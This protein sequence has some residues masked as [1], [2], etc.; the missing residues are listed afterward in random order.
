LKPVFPR[1]VAERFF[2]SELDKLVDKGEEKTAASMATALGKLI[3][4]INAHPGSG[5]PRYANLLNLP[6]LRHR[7][8]GRYRYL[9][10]YV[11]H[12]TFIDVWQILHANM[13]ILNRLRDP[14]APDEDDV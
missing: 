12:D 10:F 13:D 1:T 9:V 14:D 11:E 2:D 8:L 7:K 4:A 3:N 5:S 6:G